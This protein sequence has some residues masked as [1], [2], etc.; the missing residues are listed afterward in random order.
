M[1]KTIVTLL[2]L[3][4]GSFAFQGFQCASTEMTT[5]KMKFQ[6]K[7]FAAAEENVKKELKK[8]PKNEDAYILLAKI[9]LSQNEV[10]EAANVLKDAQPYLKT[11]AKKQEAAIMTQ[12]IF[13]QAYNSAIGFQ[14]KYY[15]EN[16]KEAFKAAIANADMALL[17]RPEMT[18]L[19]N[20]KGR[21]YESEGNVDK[22]I[23]NYKNYVESLEQ[24]VR[25][26]RET[27]LH[28]N[29]YR[30]EVLKNI[31]QPERTEKDEKRNLLTDKIVYEGNDIYV[32]YAKEKEAQ[33]YIVEG[34]RTQIPNSWTEDMAMGFTQIITDPFAALA[35][36]YMKK[37]NY[38]EAYKYADDLTILL[39][40][41]E[42]YK[43]FK[44]GIL[45]RSGKEDVALNELEKSTKE[46]PDNPRLWL[47]YADLL[48]NLGK[49]EEAVEKYKKVLEL[50]P[51]NGYAL[52]NLATTLKNIAAKV[53]VQEQD[54]LSEDKDYEINTELYF[55]TLNESAEYYQKS[56]NSKEFKDN[57]KVLMEL[58]NIYQVT[59]NEDKLTQVL[60]KLENKESEVEPENKRKF[61]LDLLKIYSNMQN[62]EKTSEIQNKIENLK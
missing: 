46:D 20:M 9:K 28:L 5:A 12:K 55:P 49:N 19:Y 16:D 61:Y 30:D 31:G 39:P 37:E 52:F 43:R 54:K 8:N 15:K 57:Y 7:D 27:P 35:D 3:I 10:I 11:N 1:K 32:S 22:A 53:Q 38:D 62:A 36:I 2:L 60:R 40:N 24:E 44:I 21:M 18:D 29:M 25:F 50:D 26:A 17:L 47:Q 13:A 59:E 48:S 42:N 6:Q 34:Y 56:L 41:N 45:Q 4:I 58:A 14:N 51:D 33:S 23:E